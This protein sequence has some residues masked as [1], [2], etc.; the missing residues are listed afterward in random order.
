MDIILL[1]TGGPIPQPM[2]GGPATLVKASDAT[3]L[4]DAGRGVLMRLAAAGVFPP[5]L[6][7]VFLT[8][9]HSD[10][11][12]DLN[13]VITTS[14]VMN[15]Q[16]TPLVVYGPPRTQ[17][18]VDG[19]LAMLKPDVSYRLAHHDD[20][21]WSPD[22]RVNEVKPGDTFTIGSAK[23]TVAESAHKPVEPT[24]AYRIDDAGASVVLG[25]DGL[26]CVG[27]DELCKGADAY[28]QTVVRDDLVR[29][30][31]NQRLQDVIDYHSTVEQ[32][33]QTAQRG[34]VKTL[35]LT[36][37]VPFM[38]PGT[39]DEWR[40]LAAKHFTGNIVLGDDLTTVSL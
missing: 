36:H 2:R 38:Q 10:H 16:P 18:I 40:A 1:G 11:I 12:T 35:V 14:W 17:E 26:P 19:I 31:P 7:A 37:Y 15:P 21:T 9:L 33:A 4:V 8:H 34:S 27:L 13:D 29:K 24:V 39:E 28:V 6:S 23:V 22:V 30:V 5:M 32:A 3:V 20:L 25:G